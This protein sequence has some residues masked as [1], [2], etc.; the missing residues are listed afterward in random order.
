MKIK[1]VWHLL[2]F[3]FLTGCLDPYPTDDI[4]G[5]V[6]AL[7]AEGFINT[8][9]Q[10]ASVRLSKAVPL[11]TTALT[12]G[13]DYAEVSIESEGGSS[14]SVPG[15]G[16][17]QYQA[18]SL[19]IDANARYRLNITLQ[20]GAKYLS[21]YVTLAQTPDIDSVTFGEGRDGINIYVNT[22]DPSGNSRYYK[23]E[24]VETWEYVASFFSNYVLVGGQAYERSPY[25]RIY[26]CW[27]TVPSTRIIINNTLRLSDD[28]VSNFPVTSQASGSVQLRKRYSINVL[29]RVLS[30]EE[31]DYWS[32]LQKTTENIGGLFDPLPYSVTGNI[33]AVNGDGLALGYFGGG[34]VKEQRIFIGLSDLPRNVL[35]KTSRVPCTDDDIFS[36]DLAGVAGLSSGSILV[37]AIYVPFIG[38]VGYTYSF[39]SCADCRTHGGTTVMPDFWIE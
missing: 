14:F 10:S 33:H 31:Y 29:Q 35:A 13:I 38:I 6:D 30:K 8:T 21:D 17:G 19:S 24:Y 28:V 32:S 27:S 7:V 34:A 25:D 26:N 20:S 16:N 9:N 18:S 39:P 4:G 36:V 12:E 22:H 3:A 15:S 5:D 37:D 23:W 1:S 2:L 11:D